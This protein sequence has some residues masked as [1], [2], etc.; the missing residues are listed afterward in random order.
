[1]GG[2][3]IVIGAGAAGLSAA[4]SL[5]DKNIKVLLVSDQPS[6]RAQSVMAEGGMNA[7]LISEGSEDSVQKHAEETLQAG[8]NL[9]DR[10]AVEGMTQAAPLIVEKLYSQ[11]MSWTLNEAKQPQR[12]AFGGQKYK[13]TAFAA[14]STGKQLMHTLTEQ[15]RRYEAEG[16]IK[17]KIGWQFLKLLYSQEKAGAVSES[18]EDGAAERRVCGCVLYDELREQYEA[19]YGEG[20][21]IASGGLNG[22]FGNATGSVRNTGYV[23]ASLFADGIPLANGEFIQYHPTTV[24]LHGKQMLITEAAR[25]EGGRLFVERNGKPYYFM[26]EKYPELGNLMPRDVVS[27]EEWKLMAEGYQIWLDIRGLDADIYKNRLRG[28]VD[29]CQTF[30]G[31]DPTKKSIPIAPGIHYFMG[32]IRVDREHRTAVRGLYAAGEC[33]CQYHG[34][35]RLGGNSLLGALYGG[36]KA[37][38]SAVFD[39]TMEEEAEDY[40][41]VLNR[42]GEESLSNSGKVSEQRNVPGVFKSENENAA[43][44]MKKL[45]S[46]LR[47][48]LGI[49]RDEKELQSGLEAVRK[50]SESVKE[51]DEADTLILENK[52]FKDS[53]LLGEA[54]LL[55]ALNRKESRGAHQ[56][57][58]YPEEL[59]AYQKTT[60]ARYTKDG[61]QISFEAIDE[62]NGGSEAWR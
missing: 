14:D 60:R 39:L 6:E 38:E 2:Q 20:V 43:D 48:S 41:H 34:A 17:R 37:A 11:G 19:V 5:A 57:S 32:G 8:R 51:K 23:T 56:R 22:L 25:G 7:A 28:V 26:E 59:Q 58:D 52:R 18:T 36:Q 61:I 47:E 53:C 12:R 27:R 16:C 40:R 1:M 13:R 10:Q 4:L 24:R 9:A 31:L 35:N 45:Q 42:T 30:L 44:R 3:I 54:M 62:G 50:L 29:A 21:I 49:I 33:A 15:V 46:I 55:S